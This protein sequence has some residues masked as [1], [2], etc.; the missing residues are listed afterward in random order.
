[1]FSA[2]FIPLL[3]FIASFFNK[4]AVWRLGWLDFTCGGLSIFGLLLWLATRV[5]N[6]AIIFSILADVLA[7]VPTI[8]KSYRAPQSESY[9]IYFAGL[10]GVVITLLTITT[11]NFATWGFPIYLVVINFLLFVLIKFPI[12]K[13]L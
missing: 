3:V 4:K 8:I 2:G 10:I 11:W 5:G 9:G 13:R 6:I 7:A 12:K 1:T